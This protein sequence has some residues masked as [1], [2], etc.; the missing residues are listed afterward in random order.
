MK[1]VDYLGKNDISIARGWKNIM[2]R[3]RIMVKVLPAL[4]IF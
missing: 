4:Y 1:R 2:H 3:G